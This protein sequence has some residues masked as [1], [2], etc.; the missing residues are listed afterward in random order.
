MAIESNPQT[1]VVLLVDDELPIHQNLRFALK[2]GFRLKSAFSEAEAKTFKDDRELKLIILDLNLD[3]HNDEFAGLKLIDYFQEH[4]PSIPII[5]ITNFDDKKDLKE[6]ALKR[7]AKAFLLKKN[8]SDE[9]VKIF[10]NHI[11]LGST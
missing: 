1:H 6:D 4:L 10:E 2:E 7:G 8:Y 3:K 11:S 5:T 9:W